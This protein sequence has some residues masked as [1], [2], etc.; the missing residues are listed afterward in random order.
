MNNSVK[1]SKQIYQRMIELC[2]LSR[3]R[4]LDAGGKATLSSGTLHNNDYLTKEEKE[5]FFILGRQ[6]TE[7]SN[8]YQ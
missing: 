1:L 8:S 4:Y 3:Q 7:K 2:Q 6:L 5:E